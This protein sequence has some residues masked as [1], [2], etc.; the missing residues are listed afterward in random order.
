[1]VE[2]T[3]MQDWLHVLICTQ[4]EYSRHANYPFPIQCLASEWDRDIASFPVSL[5]KEVNDQPDL[6]LLSFEPFIPNY[7]ARDLFKFL[8]SQLPFYRVEYKIKRG[9]VDTQIRTPR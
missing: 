5:S 1:L 4:A 2:S 7:L 9:G 6:D 3:E 8:R